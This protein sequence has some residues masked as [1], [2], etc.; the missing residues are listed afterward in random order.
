MQTERETGILNNNI[1][2]NLSGK[3]KHAGGYLWKY[4]K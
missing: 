4:D 1:A 3:T 2:Q